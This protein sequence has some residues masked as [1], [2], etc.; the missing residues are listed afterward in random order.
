MASRLWNKWPA[1]TAQEK[2]YQYLA[3]TEHSKH[4]TVAKGLDTKR[5]MELVEEIDRLNEKL[6]DFVVL[7][8]IEVDILED[9]SLRLPK[10]Q[11]A[12]WN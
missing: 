1:L 10:R 4:V 2:G 8:S 3:I 11:A 12:P 6:D 7:K 5:L 9:V